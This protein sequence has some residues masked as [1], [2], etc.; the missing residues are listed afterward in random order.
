MHEGEEA[1]GLVVD[2]DVDVEVDVCVLGL[3]QELDCLAE[4]RDLLVGRLVREELVEDTV[5]LLR[6]NPSG[7]VRRSVCSIT[8]ML[9]VSSRAVQG[10]RGRTEVG[11]VEH[12]NLLVLSDVYVCSQTRS[13][14]AHHPHALYT[15]LTSHPARVHAY[16]GP[17]C[18]KKGRTGRPTPD[19]SWDSP[20]SMPS[21]PSR[22]AASNEARVFSGY[23][24]DACAFPWGQHE[25]LQE[26]G[27]QG[28]N[29][30]HGGPSTAARPS[31]S[32]ASIAS[33]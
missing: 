8:A 22:I 23:A 11:V 10:T 27:A 2:L 30:P 33:A 26:E 9:A 3:L 18:S 24:A 32:C 25:R 1:F 5:V 29:S 12:N 6:L 20:D 4:G 31:V 15:P 17:R 7:P 14:A 13:V 21:A 16:A 19:R 28:D